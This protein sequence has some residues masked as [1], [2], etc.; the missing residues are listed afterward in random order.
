[1]KPA[2]AKLLG[3]VLFLSALW[4]GA[5]SFFAA[6]GAGT[7]LVTSPSRHAAGPV[8]RALLDLLDAESYA[9]AALLLALVVLASGTDPWARLNRAVA[10]RLLV[11]ALFATVASH[12][13]VTP[14]MLALREATGTIDLVPKGDPRRAAWGRLHGFSSALLLVRIAC[15][16]GVFLC[17]FREASARLRVPVAA[18]GVRSEGR[19]PA[20]GSP[21]PPPDPDVT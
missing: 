8:N 1:M 3:L 21:A 11:V 12:L 20:T 4:V 10:I 2:A 9:A 16:A 7:V 15:A 5:L 6:G 14:Q 17:A 18:A 19:G 13:V